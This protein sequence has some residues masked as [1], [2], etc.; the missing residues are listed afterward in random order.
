M[1]VG[2][3]WR[4][5][6][7]HDLA[8]I[9]ATISARQAEHHYIYVLC[10]ADGRPFYVGKGV[11][12][13][14]FCHE[15]EARNLPTRSHKLNVIRSIF[16]SGS[17][18]GYVLDSFFSDER[19]ALA[20]ER[21]LIQEI[22][23]HD[24]RTGPLTNQTDGGEGA[25]NP[26]LASRRRRA[27]TL[28]GEAA[29]DDRRLINEFFRSL[30]TMHSSITIKPLGARKLHPLTP[31]PE[32]RRPTSRMAQTL[33]VSAMAQAI[34]LVPRCRIARKFEVNGTACVIENGVGRDMLKAGLIK[35][36]TTGATAEDEALRLTQAGFNCVLETFGRHRLIDL[37]VIAPEPESQNH[38]FPLP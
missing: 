20:R 17:R 25:S 15:S 35:L 4:F 19:H 7:L 3:P 12:E 16:K 21:R 9:R 24:L 10:Y 23:R 8:E 36:A 34:E 29:D 11:N 26:S 1:A 33:L 13:R 31:H 28:G 22:G 18:L 14:L 37:G 27:A 2:P 38:K 30:G 6:P 5:L 32:P